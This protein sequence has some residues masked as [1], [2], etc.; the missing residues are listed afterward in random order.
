MRFEDTKMKTFSKKDIKV[1]TGILAASL[2]LGGCTGKT[3]SG[4]PLTDDPSIKAEIDLSKVKKTEYDSSLMDS[5]YKRYTFA[6]LSQTVKDFGGDDNVMVS[7]ASIMIALDMVAAGAK[8]D[9]LRQLTDLFAEGQDPIAQQAYAAAL[10]DKINSA[11]DVKFSCA[12]AVWNNSNM[13]GDKV[14]ARYVDYIHETFLAEYT[15]TEFN[16]KTCDEINGWIYNHT[17]KKI[18]NMLDELDPGTVMVL[19]NAI[20]FD[21]KWEAPYEKDHVKDGDFTASDGSVKKATF[22]SDTSYTYF[23][24]DKAT[25]FIKNYEGGEYAFLAILPNDASISANE[26]AKNFTLKDYEAFINSRTT[27]YC[28]HSRMPE[29]KSDFK[30]LMNETVG[31][32]GAKSI[33]E[34]GQADFS[35]IAGTPGEI[36]VSTILHQTHIEVDAKGTKASAAT[37]VSMAKGASVEDTSNDRYVNCDRPY[38]YAIVDTK[39]MAPVFIGTVNAV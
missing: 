20:T 22:L 2:L 39:T 19:V 30:L 29:F 38:V 4:K 14:N 24:T 23:E 32:L 25:G 10:M 31:N 3:P 36:Y 33:F 35:G 16:Q 15:V 12:N 27:D 13:L 5:E 21:A 34:P 8:K 6:L 17:D 7:P 1:L 28:V 9:S 37:V 26:F 11:K 18:K